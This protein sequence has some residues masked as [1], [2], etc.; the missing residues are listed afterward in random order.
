MFFRKVLG[1][2][3]NDFFPHILAHLKYILKLLLIYLLDVSAMIVLVPW[4]L[5]SLNIL[6]PKCS[7]RAV[8]ETHSAFR[9]S[10]ATSATWSSTHF[11]PGHEMQLLACN[12][13]STLSLCSTLSALLVLSPPR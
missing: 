3:G 10:Y 12:S 2:G 11:T 9:V 7:P 4:V 8:S 6:L 5:I 1:I 13:Y